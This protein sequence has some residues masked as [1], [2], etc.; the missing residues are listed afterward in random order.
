MSIPPKLRQPQTLVFQAEAY[1]NQL[2]TLIEQIDFSSFKRIIFISSTAVYADAGVMTEQDAVNDSPKQ[3]VLLQ[4]EQLFLAYPQTVVLRFAGLIG[5]KRHPGR[6]FAG[7]QNISGANACVNLVHQAD[8]IGAVKLLLTRPMVSQVYN[9]VAPMHP[10]K[11]TFYTAACLHMGL[12]APQ[13]NETVVTDKQ[14]DGSLITK[15]LGFVYQFE[16]PLTMLDAC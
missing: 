2:Q 4:A 8:C 16:D 6:F 5:P 14:V 13:F 9:L 12:A 1:L 3:Q 11:E 7:K 10:T 15:E